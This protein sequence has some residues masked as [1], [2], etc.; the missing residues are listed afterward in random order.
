MTFESM[1]WP[2][3]VWAFMTAIHRRRS[4]I[5]FASGEKISRIAAD[6]YRLARRL[7][8]ELSVI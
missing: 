5:I 7:I 4:E 1:A 8:G 3:F 6:A 2:S